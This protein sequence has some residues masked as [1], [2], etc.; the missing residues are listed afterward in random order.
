M[1][2]LAAD[3]DPP[4]TPPGSKMSVEASVEATRR[5]AGEGWATFHQNIK[6]MTSSTVHVQTNLTTPGTGFNPSRAY[7]DKTPN[8]ASQC[9]PCNSSYGP[10]NQTDAR[11]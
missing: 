3:E 11:E 2:S 4:T 1:T 10:R 7:G 5:M 8:D 6:L 9:G